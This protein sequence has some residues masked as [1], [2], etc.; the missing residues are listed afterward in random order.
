VHIQQAQWDRIIYRRSL[1]MSENAVKELF[2]EKRVFLL[3]GDGSL[4][5]WNTA[6]NSSPLML[7]KIREL[8]KKFI[9]LSNNDSESKKR[10]LKSLSRILKTNLD[11]DDLLLPNDIVEAFMKAKGVESFDGLISDDFKNELVENGFKY[12]IRD[13]QVV[14]V[15]FDINLTYAK[16][17]RIISHINK[18]KTFLL[19][20][21][22]PLCPYKGGQ[23]IPDAGLLVELVKAA[24]KRDPDYVFGKPYSSTIDF[25]T[26]KYRT[27]KEEMLIIGDRPGTDIKMANENGI[28]SILVK[29]QKVDES[30]YKY[31]ASVE[32]MDMLY[33]MIKDL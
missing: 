30:N 3:D 9:I 15:G 17:K 10:R 1:E 27:T 19:T 18:G 26:E 4:Y 5:M 11:K 7:K 21:I 20:H 22:D 25:V 31:D 33:K 2:L 13:P 24:V 14:L 6:F 16:I 12:D 29:N 32:S 8:G 23:E 28:S